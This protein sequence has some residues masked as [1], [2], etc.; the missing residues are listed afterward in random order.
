MYLDTGKFFFFFCRFGCLVFSDYAP[1]T[2]Q[3]PVRFCYMQDLAQHEVTNFALQT[4]LT[5]P[6]FNSQKMLPE[7]LFHY[8][9]GY[10]PHTLPRVFVCNYY[11]INMIIGNLITT[12]CFDIFLYCSRNIITEFWLSQKSSSSYK[13]SLMFILS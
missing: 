5:L 9:Q 11:N 1:S 10:A 7:S 13:R 12:F 3:S 2:Y 6:T 8:F 4:Y